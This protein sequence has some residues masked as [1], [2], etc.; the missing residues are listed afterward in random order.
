MA[1]EDDVRRLIKDLGGELMEM[2]SLPDGSGFA[3]ASFPLPKD[4]WSV[5]DPG[6]SN[7]PEMPLRVGVGGSITIVREDS[8]GRFEHTFTREQFAELLRTAGKY[9]YRCATM[10]GAEPDLDPDA[11]LQNLIVGVLG[12]WTRDGLSSDAWENP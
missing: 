12:Y 2:A 7:V 9:A 1:T 11:L 8:S 3:T 6:K 4:H 5:V 10:N